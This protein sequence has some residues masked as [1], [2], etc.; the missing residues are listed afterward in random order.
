[1]CICTNFYESENLLNIQMYSMQT[2]PSY[3]LKRELPN[4]R[5]SRVGF[6][7]LA[8]LTFCSK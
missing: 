5:N 8:L 7:T 1:M 6:S 4:S 3:N 2:F